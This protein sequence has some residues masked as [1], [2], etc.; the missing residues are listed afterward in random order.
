[1]VRTVQ[2]EAT[3]G[4]KVGCRVKVDSMRDV[5]SQGSGSAE[6]RDTY[7]GCTLGFRVF[8]VQGHRV[9]ATLGFQTLLSLALPGMGYWGSG[10]WDTG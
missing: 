2:V 9:G 4:A 10:E 6:K 8:P 3:G 1:M 7:S 5:N